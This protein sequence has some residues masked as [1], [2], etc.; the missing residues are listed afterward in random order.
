VDDEDSHQASEQAGRT[1][2]PAATP[3][4]LAESRGR[5]SRQQ[6]NRAVGL[7]ERRI[8]VNRLIA[9]NM[10]Y[11]RRKAGLT[12][13][14]LGELLGGW[15]KVAVSA[16]ERSWDGKRVRKFDGDEIAAIAS[17]LG[18][19]ITALFLPP[20]D[21]L[22]DC[23]YVLG[24]DDEGE[25]VGM[26]SLL[27]HAIPE[28]TLDGTPAMRAY[29]DRLVEAMDK[30]FPSVVAEVVATRLKERAT[31]EQLMRALGDARQSRAALE[32]F[33]DALAGLFGDN[34]LL[35]NFLTEMLKATPEGQA[36]VEK[37]ERIDRGELTP[38]EQA[39]RHR[40]AWEHVPAAERNW[41]AKLA[42]IGRD[43]FGERGPAMRGEIDQVIAEARK[44]GIEGPA[45]ARV[46]LR[47]DGTYELV[48][49][50]EPNQQQ[51]NGS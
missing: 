42:A 29:E 3:I 22:E 6:E 18:V 43:L 33:D 49:P 35:Q 21:D 11:Y 27:S 14:Q 4:R 10:A 47:H 16:A 48:Q 17:V 50:P 15:T 46:L 41:Q 2:D 38:Q 40:V 5:E 24:Y 34:A 51:A 23:R 32:E 7:P 37:D 12:Q 36:L 44:R 31:E 45:G 30:Y 13:E 25:P 1:V 26:G 39:E 19:P 20:E 9:W 8:T 28:P